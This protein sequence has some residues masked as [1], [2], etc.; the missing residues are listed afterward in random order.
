MKY[1]SKQYNK[2]NFKLTSAQRQPFCLE[3][4]VLYMFDA[5]PNGLFTVYG[6]S[7]RSGHHMA[8]VIMYVLDNFHI[9][10]AIIT[11]N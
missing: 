4:Y 1:E 6:L 3:L 11:A 9:Y 8:V 5:A 2:I 7:I 10:W